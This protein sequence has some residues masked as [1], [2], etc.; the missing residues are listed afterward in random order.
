[1]IQR[2]Q[3]L[4]LLIS[5]ILL[6]LLI[7]NP[8]AILQIDEST[9]YEIYT[10]GYFFENEVQYS[11]ALLVFNLI[12]IIFPVITIFL[13]KN[14]IL[15]MRLCIYNFILL[16][17]LQAIIVYT[18]YAT[19]SNLKAEVFLEYT[20]VLPIIA[21]ILHFIAFKYIKRDEELVKAADR[22]R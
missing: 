21:A 22:I 14:R 3:T 4:F 19:A 17:G 13:F 12:T 1:M 10:K 5:T 18:I 16:I 7:W 2:V 8:L 11:Y 20:S 9:F 15:Q 6:L